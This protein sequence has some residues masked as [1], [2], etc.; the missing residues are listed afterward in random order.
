MIVEARFGRISP[1]MIRTEPEPL[2]ARGVDELALAQREHL[3]R[4]RLGDVGDVDD[5]DDHR[6]ARSSE[7]PLSVEQPEVEAADRE[8]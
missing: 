3:P 8:R 4:D 6:R 7:L 5:A 2:L 1:T